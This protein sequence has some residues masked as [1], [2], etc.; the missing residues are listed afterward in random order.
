[1]LEHMRSRQHPYP[2]P[3]NLPP[4]L[5]AT[6][7]SGM[8]PRRLAAVLGALVCAAGGYR[9]LHAFGLERTTLF[10]LGLPA[11]MAAAVVLVGPVAGS[12]WTAAVAVTFGLV[13]AGPLFN[14]GVVSL[15]LA[16]PLFYLVAVG[17]AVACGSRRGRVVTVLLLVALGLEGFAYTLPRSTAV[18]VSHTVNGTP[19]QVEQALAV[20]PHFSAR[21]PAVLRLGFPRP[22]VER[23]GGLAVGDL[24]T[25]EFSPHSPLGLG[26]QRGPRA[27]RLRVEDHTARRVLFRVVED[28]ALDEWSDLRGAEVTWQPL[29]PGQTRVTWRLDYGRGFDPS[30]YFGPVQSYGAQQAARYLADSFA[31]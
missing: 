10:F 2:E 1:M 29:T 17:F 12:A 21:R 22:V 11:L 25:V 15:L 7:R 28:T 27:L 3:A 9:F 5:F 19:E 16:A 4:P 31:P 8:G 13:V 23:G 14:V 18:V 20:P 30:W 6:R 26:V 24:R